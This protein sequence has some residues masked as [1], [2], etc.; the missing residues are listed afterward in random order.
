MARDVKVVG[1]LPLIARDKVVGIH[2]V[3]ASV[4]RVVGTLLLMTRVKFV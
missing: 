3:M 4:V 2:L 1:T